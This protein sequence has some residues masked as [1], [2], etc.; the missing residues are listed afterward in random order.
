M[1]KLLLVASAVGGVFVGWSILRSPRGYV[2]MSVLPEPRPSKLTCALG[3][4][5]RNRGFSTADLARYAGVSR[6]E[7]RAFLRVMLRLEYI[8][9]VAHGLFFPTP[10]GWAHIKR[11]CR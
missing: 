11:A 10:I 6:A 4:V 1:N 3:T 8:V 5:A 7:T 2:G 9:S